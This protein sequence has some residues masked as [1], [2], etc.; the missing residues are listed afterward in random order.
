MAH[1]APRVEIKTS[2][3]SFVV[4]LYTAH[5]PRTCKN[6][7]EL[8]KRG[9]YNNTVVSEAT[10]PVFRP[11]SGS[12]LKTPARHNR[13]LYYSLSLFENTLRRCTASFATS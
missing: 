1:G 3:G 6:F 13:F 5:A 10:S 11:R 4:E 8:A 9:Y 12:V 7:L 2:I